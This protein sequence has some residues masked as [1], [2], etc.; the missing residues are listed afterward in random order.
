[1][2]ESS[3]PANQGATV[4]D[5]QAMGSDQESQANWLEKRKINIDDRICLKKLSHIR[6]QS[7]DLDETHR[8][9]LDFG[10]RVAQRT[11]NEVW[12]KGYG[13]DQYVYYTKKG[14]KK[15]LGGVFEAKSREDFERWAQ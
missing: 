6:Y 5:I 1:M 8:F 9:M 12:Y 4:S 2:S 13:P 15:F 7:P 11:E 14:P 10:M 3:I